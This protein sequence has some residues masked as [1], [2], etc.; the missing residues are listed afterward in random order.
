M[1]DEDEDIKEKLSESEESDFDFDDTVDG[2]RPQWD[3]FKLIPR[4]RI[5]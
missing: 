5:S 4:D 3:M 1:T 2:G